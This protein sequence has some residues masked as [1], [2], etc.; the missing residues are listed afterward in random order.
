MSPRPQHIPIL[1][2]IIMILS[3]SAL[4]AG[5][6]PLHVMERNGLSIHYEPSLRRA[7]QEVMEIYPAVEHELWGLFG[8]RPEPMP[9]ILITEG[10]EPSFGVDWEK[11]PIS[12]FALPGRD[13]I[14][15]HWG[16][17]GRDPLR[18]HDV[19]KHE[20]CHI[21]LHQR[22]RTALPRWL[23]EG[24]CQWTSDGISELLED[25]RP[26]RLNEA[27]SEGNMIPLQQLESD[28]PVGEDDLI[29][30]YEESKTFVVYLVSRF[31]KSGLL[32]FLK[33]AAEGYTVRDG[34]LRVTAETLDALERDWRTSLKGGGFWL[35]RISHFF[36][37]ILF[38]LMALLVVWGFMRQV[39]KKR[40]YRDNA[41]QD[42]SGG[43]GDLQAP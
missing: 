35:V 4:P 16:R 10:M 41:P 26:S 42:E 11:T 38:A 20:M 8:W 37:E 39:L 7:A 15:L 33:L 40:A 18:L 43:D 21:L 29:L 32:G 36:Y 13:L 14:V 1:V 17:V 9:V 6:E 34:L 12:A 24:V 30:S 22:I 5:G 3:L 27:A 31:G 2:S 28:F 19:L 23:D 25:P